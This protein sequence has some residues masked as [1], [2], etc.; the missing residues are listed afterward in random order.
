MRSIGE[1]FKKLNFQVSERETIV[2]SLRKVT[3][4]VLKS[5]SVKVKKIRKWER[6]YEVLCT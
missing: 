3:R 6:V 4:A 1:K 2:K 5:S